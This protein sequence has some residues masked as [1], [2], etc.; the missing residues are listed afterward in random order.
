MIVIPAIDLKDG[1][2]VRLQ[3]GKKDA[4]T[5]YSRDPSATAR[6]WESYGAKALHVIDLDG[7]FTG[8]QKN[9]NVI[10]E[11]RK[12]VKMVMQVGGGI[13]NIA[14]VDRLLSAGINRV[15]IGTSAIEDSAFVI[16]AC[17]KFPGKIFVGIDAKDGKVAVKGWEEI[18]SIEAKELAKRM[19]TVGISGIIYTDISRDGMLSSPNIE[20]TEEIVKSVKIPVIASGGVS[21]L[22]DIKNLLKIKNLWGVITGKAIYSGALDL[23]KAMEIAKLSL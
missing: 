11:I 18:S 9:L 23:K 2:C 17:N 5:I 1:Q 20:A 22:E 10:L 13:R 4:V 14:T 12:S 6:R 3:Q 15:I 19:E 7:A 16:E 8:N 21:C